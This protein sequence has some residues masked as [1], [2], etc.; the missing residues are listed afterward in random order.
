MSDITFTTLRELKE[1]LEP[2][3]DAQ[4]DAF[5]NEADWFTAYVDSQF[6]N[7]LGNHYFHIESFTGGEE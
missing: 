5:T 7:G 4:L 3:N 6:P 1:W 2:M